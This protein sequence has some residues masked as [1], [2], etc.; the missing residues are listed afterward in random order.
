MLLLLRAVKIAVTAIIRERFILLSH[1]NLKYYI[2]L[3]LLR[4]ILSTLSFLAFSFRNGQTLQFCISSMPIN[5][6]I[7][8]VPDVSSLTVNG[9]QSIHLKCRNWMISYLFWKNFS[10]MKV[11]TFKKHEVFCKNMHKKEEKG[12]IFARLHSLRAHKWLPLA[13]DRSFK[14]ASSLCTAS[15]PSLLHY[16]QRLYL[17]ISPSLVNATEMLKSFSGRKKIGLMFW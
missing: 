11:T 13:V 9:P 5:L 4:N 15:P 10:N 6:N 1:E 8:E 14:S 16:S 17:I 2:F 12:N 3:Q 7:Q